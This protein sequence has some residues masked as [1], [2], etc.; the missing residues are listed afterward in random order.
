MAGF[1]VKLANRVAFPEVDI[2][3]VFFYI[4]V[5]RFY[6]LTSSGSMS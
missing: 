1:I 3:F 4:E 5:Y 6:A 2:S